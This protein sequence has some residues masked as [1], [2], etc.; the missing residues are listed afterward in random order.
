MK[1]KKNAFYSVESTVKPSTPILKICEHYTYLASNLTEKLHQ[2]NYA[3]ISNIK[4]KN[5]SCD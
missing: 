3:K 1:A 4:D 5:Y 2:T